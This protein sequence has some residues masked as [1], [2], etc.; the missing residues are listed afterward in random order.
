[1]ANAKCQMP[2]GKW[3]MQNAK[4]S[5]SVGRFGIRHLAFVI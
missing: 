4:M 5:D 1:M 2:N 3:Q